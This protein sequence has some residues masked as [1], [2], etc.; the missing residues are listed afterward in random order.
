MGWIRCVSQGQ[1]GT[2]FARVEGNRNVGQCCVDEM[3]HGGEERGGFRTC[4]A[5]DHLPPPGGGESSSSYYNV[6][7]EVSLITSLGECGVCEK[8]GGGYAARVEDGCV[9]AY[10]NVVEI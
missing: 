7:T 5:G 2:G 1:R 10:R 8:R 9:G 6:D 4:H 3:V